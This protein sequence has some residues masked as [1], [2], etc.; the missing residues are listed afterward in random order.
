MHIVTEAR[1]VLNTVNGERFAGLNFRVFLGFHEYCESFSVNIYIITS[2]VY[3]MAL[4][5]YFK[6]KESQVF[7]LIGWNP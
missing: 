6:R 7:P 2:F 3:T 1:E 5:K 4:F